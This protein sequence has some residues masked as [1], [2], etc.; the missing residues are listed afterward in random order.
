VI[1]LAKRSLLVL[2]S[3]YSIFTNKFYLSGNNS[4]AGIATSP[5]KE[6]LALI[7]LS[8]TKRLEIIA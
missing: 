2:S 6:T 8:Y 1:T 5:S 7:A 3:F 4:F